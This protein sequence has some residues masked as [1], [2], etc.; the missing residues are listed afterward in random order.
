[1]PVEHSLKEKLREAAATGTVTITDATI[2]GKETQP[3]KVEELQG[4]VVTPVPP[5][6][7][8]DPLLDYGDAVKTS[9]DLS[10][11]AEKSR[12]LDGN[13]LKD[14]MNA[15][16]TVTI[17][18]ED[19]AAFLD[20]LVTGKRY[21]RPFSIYGG[22]IQ[23]TFR[24]RSAEESEA[25]ASWMAAGIRE[26]RYDTAVDYSLELRNIMLAAHVHTLNATQF[27]ELKAP[28]RRTQDGTTLVPPGWIEQA[29]FWTTLPE[30]VLG[31]VYEEI[32]LFE[33]KYW[34]MIENAS[35]QDFWSPVGSS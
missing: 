29:K 24:C 26:K 27:P 8:Q 6:A 4:D 33:R 9:S 20:V 34:T 12:G 16:D 7:K 23:G 10:R 25:I 15:V 28:L 11:T 31:G 1:M 22:A 5:M 19:R 21:C 17:T 13:I 30:T 18:N 2:A 14:E 35:N 32:R 3:V